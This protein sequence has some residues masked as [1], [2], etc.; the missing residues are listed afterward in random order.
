MSKIS[1]I[2]PV[3]NTEK[4]IDEC[5][6]SCINQTY[7]DYEII[8]V[9]DGSNDNSGVICD[10][11]SKK[12]DRIKVFHYENAGAATARNRGIDRATGDYVCFIDSD[13]RIANNY[14]EYLYSLISNHTADIAVCGHTDVL[15][16]TPD[17]TNDEK[18]DIVEFTGEEAMESLLYQKYFISAPWGALSSKIIWD[19]V[20]FPDGRRVEDVATI[21]KEYAAAKKVVYGSKKLYYRYLWPDST[22]YTTFI[23]KNS[24]YQKHLSDMVAYVK[25]QYPER[26]NSAYHRQFSGC[27]QILSETSKSKENA[28]F[29]KPVYGDIRKIR[30]YVIKDRKA[31]IK[32]RVA[33]LLSYVSIDLL[34]ALLRVYYRIHLK[35]VVNQKK[36]K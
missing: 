27:F 17:S 18:E 3:Y 24:E 9:D 34:H 28:Y 15:D 32:N 12:D 1:I 31:R 6:S 23:E 11:W 25:Q 20:R 5:L 2:I 14:L 16:G 10:A 8:L 7:K 13:D 33:A 30:K 26:V 36:T 19:T 4:Y 35:R 22:I 21:Y 29:L